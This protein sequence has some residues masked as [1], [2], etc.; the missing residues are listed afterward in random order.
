MRQILLEIKIEQVE[1]RFQ[2]KPFSNALSIL[3]AEHKNRG[4]PDIYDD[5]VLLRNEIRNFLMYDIFPS[6]ILESQIAEALNWL[7]GCFIRDPIDVYYN[8]K[9]HAPQA[10]EMF[11]RIKELNLSRFLKKSNIYDIKSIGELEE[12]VKEAEP[13]FRNH[14]K[15]K[16]NTINAGS[17]S[18]KIFENSKWEVYIP[19]NKAAS[20]KLGSGTQ[21]CTSMQGLNWY[22]KYHS[23]D[24]PLIIF[25]SKSSPDEKYQFYFGLKNRSNMQFMN[26]NN[27]SM[28]SDDVDEYY[29]MPSLSFDNLSL[30]FE[31]IEILKNINGKFS[32]HLENEIKR[33]G[34]FVKNADDFLVRIP[35]FEY[36]LDKRKKII[37]L[38]EEEPTFKGLNG[39]DDLWCTKGVSFPTQK[40]LEDYLKRLGDE[41]RAENRYYSG[42]YDD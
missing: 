20:C 37:E 30:F 41:E 42:R 1:A 23:K 33:Y 40:H 35:F 38:D 17:G 26:A 5:E 8:I 4:M 31:F 14:L 34:I 22:E 25:I 12:I 2:S 15:T 29:E 13:A 11:Y 32:P 7:I 6:D 28:I 3:A 18:N 10:L 24:D 21:W 9:Q 36:H 27:E 19:E 16:V 39:Y